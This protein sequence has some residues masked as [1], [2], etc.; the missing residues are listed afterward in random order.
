MLRTSKVPV[1]ML[2][3][4]VTFV[5]SNLILW[6]FIRYSIRIAIILTQESQA[7]NNETHIYNKI[8]FLF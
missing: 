1:C 2:V 5:M 7:T 8:F 3:Q 4:N 6:I